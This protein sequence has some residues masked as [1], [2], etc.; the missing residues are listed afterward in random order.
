[1]PAA[2]RV[3]SASGSQP[4]PPIVRAQ[5]P[6]VPANPNEEPDAQAARPKQH[7]KKHQSHL[8][9]RH[10]PQRAKPHHVQQRARDEVDSAHT[11]Q[12]PAP[13]PRDTN[14][15]DASK[16]G[17]NGAEPEHEGRQEE[18]TDE[19]DAG[20]H[21]E[22]GEGGNGH[23]SSG[24]SGSPDDHGDDKSKDKE[25]RGAKP[26]HDDGDHGHNHDGDKHDDD[27]HGDDGN[28]D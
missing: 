10:V 16:P 26:P 14:E 22:D 12:A 3:L 20:D 15:P 18:D 7:D 19:S 9:K 25:E 21:D 6:E 2:V 5:A 24:G 28:D 11:K 8:K 1:M 13:E 23:G 27:D 17:T 4:S